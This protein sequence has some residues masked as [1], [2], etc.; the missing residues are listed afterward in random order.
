MK[1]LGLNCKASGFHRAWLREIENSLR[2]RGPAP[3]FTLD[4]FRPLLR[5]FV[6]DFSNTAYFRLRPYKYL[7]IFEQL[8]LENFGMTFA[9][10]RAIEWI[11]RPV[12][13]KF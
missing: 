7:R 13:V 8:P 5:E 4:D 3:V 6:N 10:F 9:S 12:L 2:W 11:V 1:F